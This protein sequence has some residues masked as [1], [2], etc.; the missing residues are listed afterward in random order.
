MKEEAKSLPNLVVIM[1]AYFEKVSSCR[2]ITAVEELL[3]NL[4]PYSPGP[5]SDGRVSSTTPRLTARSPSTRDSGS[6]AL[7]SPT[8][9]TL[10]CP[11]DASFSTPSPLNSS[12]TAFRGEPSALAPLV[13]S[14]P[15][16]LDVA[17]RTDSFLHP[18]SPSF[19][20]SSR[21][22]PP[23]PSVS[24]FAEF[25]AQSSCSSFYLSQD[26]R[27]EPMDPSPSLSTLCARQATLTLSLESPSLDSPP[28]SEQRVSCSL[29]C[30]LTSSLS[31]RFYR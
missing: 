9:P 15:T 1:R 31:P 8:S 23:S 2:I 12:P 19:T 5:P 21:P 17:Q 22:E 27:T 3:A 6:L 28:S 18:Q 30:L 25:G 14:H 26:S 4:S 24:C 20:A 7:F 10:A 16:P 29:S 11:S 13:S